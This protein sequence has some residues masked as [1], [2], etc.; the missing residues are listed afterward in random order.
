M[1]LAPGVRLGP[2]AVV[3]A[4]G[5]GA[6]ARCMEYSLGYDGAGGEG[7]QSPTGLRLAFDP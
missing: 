3:S 5:A 2:Y 7:G 4:I 6:W 1:A